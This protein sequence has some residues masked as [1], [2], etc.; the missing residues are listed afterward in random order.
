MPLRRLAAPEAQLHASA[1]LTI[2]RGA[3]GLPEGSC[4][5]LLEAAEQALDQI[6]AG[7]GPVSLALVRSYLTEAIVETTGRNQ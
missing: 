6:P 2:N 5:Q 4:I 1:G 3:A 7:E